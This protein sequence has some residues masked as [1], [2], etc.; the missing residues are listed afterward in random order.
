MGDPALAP[1]L[2]FVDFFRFFATLLGIGQRHS[3]GKARWCSINS[4]PD[5]AQTWT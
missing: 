1:L 3:G 5:A 4:R 2:M